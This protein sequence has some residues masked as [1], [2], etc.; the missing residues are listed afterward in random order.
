MNSELPTDMQAL[1][2]WRP[3]LAA[4]AFQDNAGRSVRDFENEPRVTSTRHVVCDG[5]HVDRAL[6][7]LVIGM[8]HEAGA[9]GQWATC[10]RQ[11]IAD[12]S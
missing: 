3:V 10:I 11:R 2:H 7:G 8:R 6:D 12:S 9:A 5:A 4:V 1:V